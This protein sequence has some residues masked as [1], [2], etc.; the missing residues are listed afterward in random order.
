MNYTNEINMVKDALV[1]LKALQ[2][3]SSVDSC[4]VLVICCALLLI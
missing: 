2:S 4:T 3:G 1:I